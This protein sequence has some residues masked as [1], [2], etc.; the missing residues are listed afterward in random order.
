MNPADHYLA[1]RVMT[2]TPAQLTGMLFDALT[3]AVRGAARLQGQGDFPAALPRS[4]K[5]QRIPLELRNT[6]DHGV[7]GELA[8]SLDALYTWSH[9]N[10]V[11]AN[12]ER[13]AAA[14]ARVLDVV[15]QL[16]GAWNEGCLGLVPQ[17]A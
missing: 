14:T 17:P 13:D 6:L 12:R 3:A 10:L 9:A 15:E 4:L 16:A 2:A 11:Q 1:E 7:G 8:R 5:A